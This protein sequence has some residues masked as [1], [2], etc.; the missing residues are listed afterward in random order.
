VP[1]KSMTAPANRL[2]ALLI[3][4]DFTISSFGVRAKSPK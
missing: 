4:S 1:E 2:S 3:I